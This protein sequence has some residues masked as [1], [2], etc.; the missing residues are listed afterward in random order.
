MQTSVPRVIR[1]NKSHSRTR[2]CRASLIRI[3][4]MQLFFFKFK[5][6]PKVLFGTAVQFWYCEIFSAVK[7]TACVHCD[8]CMR[9]WKSYHYI[10]CFALR[11][12]HGQIGDA[13]AD[14]CIC[15][16]PQAP[17]KERKHFCTSA[18]DENVFKRSPY[19]PWNFNKSAHASSYPSI[20]RPQSR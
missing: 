18:D 6:L 9:F 19:S 7:L 10:R 5:I 8:E 14:Q 11:C 2:G 20:S 1:C 12:A 13:A 15:C 16:L 3:P 17:R 4:E